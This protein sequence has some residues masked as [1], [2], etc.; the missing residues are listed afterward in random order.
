MGLDEILFGS[1]A[2]RNYLKLFSEQHWNKIAKATFLLGIYRLSDLA[3][4]NDLTLAQL[5]AQQVEDLVVGAYK[6]FEKRKRHGD[7]RA[8][9]AYWTDSL[10]ESSPKRHP[11]KVSSGKKHR[12][13]R[14]QNYEVVGGGM[15]D[16]GSIPHD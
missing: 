12:K 9:E 10:C 7:K 6:K 5:T 8:A 4:H 3:R 13:N 14:H 15:L 16:H 11:Q 2:I 1:Q